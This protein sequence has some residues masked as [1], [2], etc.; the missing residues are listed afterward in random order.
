MRFDV[1]HLSALSFGA[2]ECTAAEQDGDGGDGGRG[3]GLCAGGEDQTDDERCG[4]QECE[5]SQHEGP[6]E[7]QKAC[8]LNLKRVR[9]FWVARP[10]ESGFTS[11]RVGGKGCFHNLR[12]FD[13]RK[14]HYALSRS[15]KR[16]LR[17][18][19]GTRRGAVYG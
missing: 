4:A 6:D 7:L 5:V 10:Y 11:V 15:L 14:L 17:A 18:L 2:V 16:S 8:F 1:V 13:K 19:S 3:E 9:T 12:C